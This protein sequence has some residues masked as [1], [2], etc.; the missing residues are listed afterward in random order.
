MLT[1]LI[2]SGDN[3]IVTCLVDE[4]VRQ[5]VVTMITTDHIGVTDHESEDV[6]E[7]DM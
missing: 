4:T 7:I 5:T 2:R 6:H 3:E 1:G